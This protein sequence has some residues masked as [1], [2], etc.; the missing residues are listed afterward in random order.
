MIN[1]IM[2]KYKCIYNGDVGDGTKCKFHNQGLCNNSDFC[3]N[4]V[5]TRYTHYKN[6]IINFFKMLILL[7][8]NK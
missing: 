8:F 2:N 5:L 4:K 7:I 3:N 1:N 6:T